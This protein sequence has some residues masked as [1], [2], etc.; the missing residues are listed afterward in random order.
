MKALPRPLPALSFFFL[1]SK[2]NR[3]KLRFQGLE[4]QHISL[5]KFHQHDTEKKK[6]QYETFILNSL[7]TAYR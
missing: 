6:K 2:N 7:V 1:F 3:K 5:M 4:G